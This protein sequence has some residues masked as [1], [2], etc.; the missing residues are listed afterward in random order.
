MAE[1]QNQINVTKSEQ[2]NKS[3]AGKTH[4]EQT[5]TKRCGHNVFI[6]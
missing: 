1:A 5:L 3:L 6:S 4:G 2:V